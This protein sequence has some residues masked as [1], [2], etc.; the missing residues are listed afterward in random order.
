MRLAGCAS[1][2]SALTGKRKHFHGKS[3]GSGFANLWRAIPFGSL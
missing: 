1:K 2:E 3:D